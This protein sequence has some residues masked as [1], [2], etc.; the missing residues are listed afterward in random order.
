MSLLT[1]VL[2]MAPDNADALYEMTSCRVRL[3]LFR[4]LPRRRTCLSEMPDQQARGLVLLAAIQNDLGS[5]AEA[6][7]TYRQVIDLAPDGQGLQIPPEELFTQYGTVLLHQGQTSAAVEWLE[8]SLANRPTAETYYYL[9]NVHAQA[10]NSGAAEQAWQRSLQL[11][12]GGIPAHEAL[13]E[14]ALQR[15]DTELALKR[16]R[17][18][19][20]VAEARLKTA[21]LFLRVAVKQKDRA[22]MERWQKKIQGLRKQDEHLS[23]ME[24]LMVSSPHSFWANVCAGPP[25]RRNG[26]LAASRG[27]DRG[28]GAR[29]P[30]DK[31]V[32][33]LAEAIRKRGPLPSV[34]R[35]PFRHF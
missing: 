32:R 13:A 30:E 33:E 16:L 6:L 12:S 18:L 7:K 23:M 35:I 1:Q 5:P 21:N 10:G 15:G 24:Q 9:G 28:A 8:K 34:E 4:R 27:H 11:D 3:G 14:S 19:Q 22:A 26:E 31:F 20:R 17:P 2:R 25:L 29:V